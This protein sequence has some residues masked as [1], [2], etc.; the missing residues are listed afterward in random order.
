MAN[1]QLLHGEDKMY[2]ITIHW[3]TDLPKGF[4]RWEA[5]GHCGGIVPMKL[6]DP[7]KDGFNVDGPLAESD[8]N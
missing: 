8:C 5:S 4:T 1:I 3:K 2:S 6:P 7:I